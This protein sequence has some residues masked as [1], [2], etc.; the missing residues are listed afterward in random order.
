MNGSRDPRQTGEMPFLDHL[1]ELRSV[2]MHTVIAALAG[3]IAGWML[4]PRVLEDLIHRT[5]AETPF[6]KCSGG[7]EQ[8]LAGHRSEQLC[9]E[10]FHH[11]CR[12]ATTGTYS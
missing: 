10:R 11:P 3:A 9:G 7:S 1:D 4:A 6:V 5:V 8:R 12:R 2:L